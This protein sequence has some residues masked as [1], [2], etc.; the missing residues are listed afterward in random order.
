MAKVIHCR[1]AGFDCDAVIRA[2]TEEEA[3]RQA[4]AHAKTAHNMKVV[5]PDV[6]AHI[7]SVMRDE[8]TA[9]HG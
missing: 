2:E 9:S 6:A 1:D 7:K 4:A 5:T 3:M 8:P